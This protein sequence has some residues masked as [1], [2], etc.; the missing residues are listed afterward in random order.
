MR[1]YL[2]EKDLN[3]V[4]IGTFFTMGASYMARE[5]DEWI[6]AT[7]RNVTG[8][9]LSRNH[10]AGLPLTR[11]RI[12]RCRDCRWFSEYETPNDEEYPHFCLYHGTDLERV[13]GFCA[14]AERTEE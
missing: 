1:S 9:D 11:E 8:E 3:D 4:P 14:W 13:D 10:A 7:P 2:S 6:V 5:Y 12:I